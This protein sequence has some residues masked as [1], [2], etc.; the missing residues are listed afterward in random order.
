MPDRE[1]EALRT[2]R[3][4]ASELERERDRIEGEIQLE[5]DRHRE[6]LAS[7]FPLRDDVLRLLSEVKAVADN[8]R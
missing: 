5:N 6:A 4:R 1:H 7:L 2:L 8:L 3:Q